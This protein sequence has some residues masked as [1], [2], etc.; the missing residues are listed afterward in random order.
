[1]RLL[2]LLFAS[3]LCLPAQDLKE[4]EKK[5]AEFTLANGLH[6]IVVE[7]HDAPVVSFHTYVDA[8]SVND[9][10]GHTG[11]AHMFEHMAFKGTETIG[12]TN[13]AAERKALEAVESAYDRLEAEQA[14]ESKADPQR[15]KSLRAELDAAIDAANAYVV[16]NEY[17]RIIEENGGAGLNASTSED[18]T[19]Y[20]YSLPSNRLEL[21][22]LLESQRFVQPVFRE[23]YKERDVVREERRMRV[24]SSPQGKLVEALLGTAF[25]A[26]SY[27]QPTAGWASDIERLRVEDAREFFRQH[28]G[29]RNLTI[30]IVGDV[31]PAEARKLAERYFGPLKDRGLP[32]PAL[33][34]EPPQN[35]EK[36]VTVETPA[37][38]FLAIA[39]KRPAQDHPD[40]PVFDVLSGILASGRT[41]MLYKE[42]V[43]DKR[44]ALVASSAPAF[45]GAQYP[46]LFLFYLVPNS[47]HTTD[48]LEKAAYGIVDR[49]KNEQVDE[50]TLARVKTKVRASLIRQ[51][52]S[53]T[54]L[55]SQV[56]WYHVNYGDWR[57]LFTALE[58]INRVTAADV[59][60]V[61]RQYLAPGG[62]TVAFTVPPAAAGP[63][64][65]APKGGAQ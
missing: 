45:P 11:L 26:H 40:D 31:N 22:F 55:A 32:P 46:G 44:I 20:Y 24:E 42:L 7:R 27:R 8:G 50:A 59:Q 25:V 15:L 12:T 63:K 43:R 53:N 65:A 37:Q 16:P 34:V 51:L 47:G 56:T 21:W 60:R 9:P 14:K 48:E 41:G 28:Y 35:G 52:D 61:A 2:T 57:K 38:P 36:R 17:P 49:L 10:Q 23:F 6:F 29:P 62:R 39:Y 4:F 1:M 33:T 58:D 19:N 18:S 64:P 30:A 54:G 13:W 3:A 5:V